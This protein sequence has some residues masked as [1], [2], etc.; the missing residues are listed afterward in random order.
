M[1]RKLGS[2]CGKLKGISAQ[3]TEHENWKNYKIHL[4]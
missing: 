4:K 1:Y 3:V 2:E